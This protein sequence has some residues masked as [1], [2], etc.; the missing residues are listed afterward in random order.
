MNNTLSKVLQFLLGGLIL[1]GVLLAVVFFV[2][3]GN[4]NPEA[5]FIEQENVLSGLLNSYMFYAYA[6]AVVALILTVVF[7][8]VKM[9]TDPKSAIKTFIS[10]A[11]LLVIAFIGWIMASDVVLKMPG[12]TGTDNV[13]ETLKVS[14]MLLYTMYLAG[15]AA[16][17]TL[18]Y[19]EVSKLFR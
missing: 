15:A 2:A 14:G 17:L 12:Y 6:L 16:V 4:L 11:V 8:V 9:V 10:I 19:A 5:N 13:P 18:I 7:A 1:V 3:V